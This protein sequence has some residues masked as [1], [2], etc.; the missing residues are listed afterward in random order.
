LPP[1]NIYLVTGEQHAEAAY[2]LLRPLGL[3][4]ENLLAEPVERNTA[5][6]IAY[7]TACLRGGHE[8]EVMAVFPADHHI[9]DPVAFRTALERGRRAAEA[10][11]MVTLGLAPA[12]AE[13]GYGYVQKGAALEG[14]EGAF[15][16]G[17][18][19][20]KPD[21][22][23]AENFLESGGHFWNT[24]I[25]LWRVRTLLDELKTHLPSHHEILPGLAGA[26][27]HGAPWRVLAGEARERFSALDAVSI[28]HGLMEKSQRVALV[29]AAFPWSDLGA[30]T[31]LEDVYAKDAAGNITSG[32]TLL[33]DTADSIVWGDSRL[34]A[35]LGLR[36]LIVI[37]TPDAL[38]VCPKERAQ[39]VREVARRLREKGRIEARRPA[40][41][42]RPWGHFTVLER[43]DGY[44]IKRIEVAPGE[45]LSLQSHEH[46]GETWTVVRGVAEVILGDKT[47]QLLPNNPLFI[48]AGLKHRLTNAGEGALILIE[49][50][51]GLRLD[52][53]DI[54][55]YEDKYGRT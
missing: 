51:T 28:D 43:G 30:W 24:G 18:F 8:N 7:A 44:Q 54:H 23:C 13:T 53:D 27:P 42:V 21:R 48:P 17:A 5:A 40:T 41:G 37:D 52:E 35:A 10:E 49:V 32:D 26:R 25:F 20:E 4:V 38:L 9:G 55:R 33:V 19:I 34:V 6:A 31:A 47:L 29:P 22:A 39:D 50:Q 2:H 1:E 12:R 46:H 36:G 45:R 16:A 3:P 14:V 11:R 15:A